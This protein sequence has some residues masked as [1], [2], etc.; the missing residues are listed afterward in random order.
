MK[1]GFLRTLLENRSDDEDIFIIYYDRAEA[2]ED[3]FNLT[4]TASEVPELTDKEWEYLYERMTEDE[5]IFQELNEAWRYNLTNIMA[6]R[7][8]GEANVNSK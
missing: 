4:P 3:L 5:T 2:S 1:I 7:N 6:Q 8:E